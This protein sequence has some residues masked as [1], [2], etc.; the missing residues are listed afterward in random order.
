ML[1]VSQ[2]CI[3]FDTSVNQGTEKGKVSNVQR[4]K[5]IH[6]LML[7]DLLALVGQHVLVSMTLAHKI[8]R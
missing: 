7:C 3:T 1:S 6:Y 8:F 2:F 5:H 4:K